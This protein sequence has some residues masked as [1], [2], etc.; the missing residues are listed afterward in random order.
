MVTHVVYKPAAIKLILR[1]DT[2]YELFKKPRHISCQNYN[3][4]HKAGRDLWLQIKHMLSF[5]C[6]SL[7]VFLLS[8]WAHESL[9]LLYRPVWLNEMKASVS[10]QSCQMMLLV[11][12][13]SW[14]PFSFSSTAPNGS[15]CDDA[16]NEAP[17]LSEYCIS[18]RLSCSG[19][20]WY[21]YP[22]C[23]LLLLF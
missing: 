1:L 15:R 21:L 10:V 12:V 11:D 23:S 17:I 22:I 7:G 5:S 20:M 8:L 14:M 13:W 6:S 19:Y 2:E 9:M 4:N 3:H 18:K 16:S